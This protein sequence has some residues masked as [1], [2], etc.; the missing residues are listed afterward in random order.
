VCRLFSATVNGQPAHNAV[1]GYDP[2]TNAW[3]EVFFFDDGSVVTQLY[4]ATPEE[5]SGSPVGKVL[6]G[7]AELVHA[8]GDIEPSD[9]RVVFT[10][11]NRFEYSV[12]NRQ[13]NG[14]KVPDMKIVFERK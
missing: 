1:A 12:V 6:K 11:A 4:R 14:R 2:K 8:N 9:L 7:T 10:S 3:K 5:L 13:M